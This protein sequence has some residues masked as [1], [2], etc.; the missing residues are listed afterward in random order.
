[1]CTG[2]V[3][4]SL[5]AFGR[6]SAHFVRLYPR[7]IPYATVNTHSRDKTLYNYPTRPRGH[8]VGRVCA[9][10]VDLFQLWNPLLDNRQGG[11][12]N[13]HFQEN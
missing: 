1:M 5:P 8:C 4:P 10:D 12:I 9:F 11:S 7:H 6:Y 13:L 3:G 2:K